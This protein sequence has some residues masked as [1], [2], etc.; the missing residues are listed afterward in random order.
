MRLVEDASVR[1]GGAVCHLP[2]ERLSLDSMVRRGLDI[3]CDLM[4][5][6]NAFS[7][8][9]VMASISD[10]PGKGYADLCPKEGSVVQL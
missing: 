7:L 6:R 9:D 4:D 1:E 8:S 5:S 2:H 10:R 3:G